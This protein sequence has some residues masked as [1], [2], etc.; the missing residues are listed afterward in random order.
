M[1]QL[2]SQIAKI[3]LGNFKHTSSYVFVLAEKAAGSEAEIYVIVELPLLNPAAIESCENI[4]LAIASGLKQVYRRPL[5]SGSFEAATAQINDELG[6]LASMGQVDWVNK[7]T[8]VLAVKDSDNFTIATCG[9]AA[10]FLF[11]GG[12]FVDISCSPAAQ[13]HPLKTFENFAVGKIK[14]NDTLLLSTPQLFNYLA[15]DRIKIILSSPDFLSAT[16]AVVELLKVNAGPE[17][18]FGTILNRQ[19]EPG[20][21]G[22]EEIDLENYIAENPMPGQTAAEKIKA[23]AKSLLG[24]GLAK[25]VSGAQL[26]GIPL[27]NKLMGLNFKSGT[28]AVMDKSKSFWNTL[29]RGVAFSRSN[30]NLENIKKIPPQR[31]FLLASALILFLALVVN[32]AVASHFKKARQQDTNMASRLKNI[33]SLV[34]NAKTSLLYNDQNSAQHYLA[35]AETDFPKGSQ[36]G[37][38]NK[39][40]YQSVAGELADMENKTQKQVP[41]EVKNLGALSQAESLIKLP[42]I[43]A[44]QSNGNIISYNKAANIMEDGKLKAA[45][46][47]IDSVYVGK[48]LAAI[49]TGKNLRL[50]DTLS[51]NLSQPFT[52][53]VTQQNDF[54]GLALYPTNSRVY[55]VNKQAGQIISFL[56]A[57]SSISKP[58]VA[59]NDPALKSAESLAIDGAVYVL[60]GTGINKY[61]NGKLAEFKWPFLIKPFSGKGKIY[62]EKDFT[63]IYVLDIGNNRILIMDKKGNLTSTLQSDQFTKMADFQVDEKN[64]V[65]YMLNDGSLL[66]VTLP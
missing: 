23:Y 57:G 24:M 46:T 66:K 4:S 42:E 8:C 12:E 50:W 35:Q 61:Q 31:K 27:K 11:R 59:V 19:V 26:P 20:Y 63:N 54:A 49:Y 64:K 38:A 6:K 51:G 25:R 33:Q 21:A 36:V 55:I 9:K 62:T 13:S 48:D 29:G 1:E 15:M 30:L 41:A 45:D 28:R 34:S 2:E 60:T 52:Q 22:E 37:N 7:L 56:I 39:S 18:A 32:L 14:L 5:T 65:I 47:I 40:L 58:V 17:V 3:Q 10:A 53:S 44:T 16:R 43:L